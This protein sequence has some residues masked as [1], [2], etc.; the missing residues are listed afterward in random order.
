MDSPR[1]SSRIRCRVNYVQLLGC[2]SDE[3]DFLID[4]SEVPKS[5]KRKK[6][7]YTDDKHEEQDSPNAF[8]SKPVKQAISPNI[9]A[10]QHKRKPCLKN[11]VPISNDITPPPL[12]M[13]PLLP[14]PAIPSSSSGLEL[15]NVQSQLQSGCPTTSSPTKPLTPLNGVPALV[16]GTPSSALRLGLS[17]KNIRRSLHPNIKLPR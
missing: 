16:C 4:G 14:V 5:P 7:L 11:S 12:T 17:R 13:R 9:A 8:E 6:A 1:K 2:D 3:D 10:R 15:E